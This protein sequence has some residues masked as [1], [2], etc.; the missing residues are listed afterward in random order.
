MY[1]EGSATT[2]GEKMTMKNDE[3]RKTRGALEKKTNYIEKWSTH[4][5]NQKRRYIKF[6]L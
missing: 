2:F 1:L 5:N 4:D 3:I 6:V